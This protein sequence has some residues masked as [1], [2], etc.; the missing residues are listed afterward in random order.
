[1]YFNVYHVKKKINGKYLN[2]VNV[3]E[4]TVLFLI[5]I[6]KNVLHFG[7]GQRK[8]TKATSENTLSIIFQFLGAKEFVN[9]RRK[10]KL[11]PNGQVSFEPWP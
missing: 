6:L 9:K 4:F 11:V 8:L 1:M 10:I 3:I 5:W 2:P 7:S